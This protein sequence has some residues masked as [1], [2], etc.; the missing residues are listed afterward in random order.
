MLLQLLK[1]MKSQLTIETEVFTDLEGWQINGG[2]IP[3]DILVSCGKGSKPDI[4]L[5][6]RSRKKIVI[7]ELTCSLPQSTTSAHNKKQTNYLLFSALQ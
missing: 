7:L 6:D 2:T 5:I 4:V 1:H 3:A